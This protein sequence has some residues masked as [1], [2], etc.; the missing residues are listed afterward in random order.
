[1]H[2]QI[3]GIDGCGKSYQARTVSEL[4]N[5]VTLAQP[6]A[7]GL[8]N[9]VLPA[10]QGEEATKEQL[11]AMFVGDRIAQYYHKVV[12]A[13]VKGELVIT[14]RSAMSTYAYQGVSKALREM[15]LN[16]HKRLVEPVDLIILIETDVG[17][18]QKR[19]LNRPNKTK[20]DMNVALQEEA[21]ER[22]YQAATAFYE[23]FCDDVEIIDGNGTKEDITKE[24]L[25]VIK[26]CRAA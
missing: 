15:I 16:T 21:S 19:L 22:Y 4:L 3:D 14:E 25:E 18:A 10:L 6:S 5:A 12:P 1:M 24:I 17:V 9:G 23:V 26:A 11:V 20:I 2:V 7:V 13:L 8:C